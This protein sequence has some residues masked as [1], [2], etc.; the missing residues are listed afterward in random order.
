MF[1]NERHYIRNPEEALKINNYL[2]SIDSSSTLITS[3]S[4]LLNKNMKILEKLILIN[5]CH[6]IK[7]WLIKN[8]IDL[9]YDGSINLLKI[10]FILNLICILLAVLFF[11]AFQGFKLLRIHEVLEKVRKKQYKKERINNTININ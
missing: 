1:K 2:K 11:Q 4:E 6:L 5:K 9:C 10:F 3:Y 8:E 7:S